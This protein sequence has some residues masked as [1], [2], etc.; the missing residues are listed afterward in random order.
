MEIYFF[1]ILWTFFTES[2]VFRR[3]KKCVLNANE[4]DVMFKLKNSYA[5]SKKAFVFSWWEKYDK[6]YDT[7][8]IRFRQSLIQKIK[9][10]EV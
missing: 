8:K 6:V 9:I 3:L 7:L 5:V 10:V 4:A 1:F 2:L